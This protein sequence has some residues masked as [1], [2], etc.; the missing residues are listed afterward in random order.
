MDFHLPED[1]SL[2]PLC[3]GCVVYDFKAHYSRECAAKCTQCVGIR[4]LGKT[5]KKIIIASITKSSFQLITATII[6]RYSF[7]Y[8]FNSITKRREKLGR[9][10]FTILSGKHNAQSAMG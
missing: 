2:E 7:D 8:A 4:S 10:Q 9:S 3:D 6:R 1:C 5:I